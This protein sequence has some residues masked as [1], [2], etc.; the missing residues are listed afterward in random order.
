[1][2]EKWISPYKHNLDAIYNQNFQ[3]KNEVLQFYIMYV[4]TCKEKTR[5]SRVKKNDKWLKNVWIALHWRDKLSAHCVL[6]VV[7]RVRA[8]AAVNGHLVVTPTATS[9][10]T[11][12]PRPAST[13]RRAA[14]VAARR[15]PWGAA[16]PPLTTSTTVVVGVT[17]PVVTPYLGPIT[18]APIHCQKKLR[19]IY[20][21]HVC[22]SATTD[23]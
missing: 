8:A 13:A 19:L 9:T 22:H 11:A 17:V 12:R 18:V 21:P 14:L 2:N 23:W 15:T 6:V 16:A 20:L 3:Q 1:M 5:H 10:R 4:A 7:V